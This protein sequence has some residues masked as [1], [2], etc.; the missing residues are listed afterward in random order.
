[1]IALPA[2][3]VGGQQVGVSAQDSPVRPLSLSLSLSHHTKA[4]AWEE[5][6]GHRE[7][8]GEHRELVRRLGDASEHRHRD[9]D[10]RLLLRLVMV[11]LPLLPPPLLRR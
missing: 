11:L 2:G 5:P 1:M 6:A 7:G 3:V 8:G 4:R 10:G 9:R